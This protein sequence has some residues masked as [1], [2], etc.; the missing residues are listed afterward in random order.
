MEL[1]ATRDTAP[2]IMPPPVADSVAIAGSEATPREVC[3]IPRA[4]V[5]VDVSET[6]PK[7]V[8]RLPAERITVE[9]RAIA[10]TSLRFAPRVNT[11]TTEIVVA[12]TLTTIPLTASV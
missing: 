12:P 11:G 9:L 5:L 4:N 6:E 3:T 7:V 8:R 2:P 10:A 1:D